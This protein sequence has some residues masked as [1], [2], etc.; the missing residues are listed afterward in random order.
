MDLVLF[1]LVLIVWM[2]LNVFLF[3]SGLF[4]HNLSV[5][6]RMLYCVAFVASSVAMFFVMSNFFD[7][8]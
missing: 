7:I 5:K 6:A 4:N 8:L 2:M 3:I 1:Y